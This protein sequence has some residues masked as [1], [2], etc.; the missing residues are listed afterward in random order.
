MSQTRYL[1]KNTYRL[2]PEHERLM[3]ADEMWA[4]AA[5]Q[6]HDHERACFEAAVIL[7][8]SLAPLAWALSMALLGGLR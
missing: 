8:V 7:M 5:R 4:F 2:A 1:P 6:T 3:L